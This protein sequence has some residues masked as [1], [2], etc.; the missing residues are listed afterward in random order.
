LLPHPIEAGQPRTVAFASDDLSDAS[1]SFYVFG[2][3]SLI[4]AKSMDLWLGPIVGLGLEKLATLDDFTI[5]EVSP[6]S[7][8]DVT[9]SDVT[10]LETSVSSLW[11]GIAADA[12]FALSRPLA[13]VV[14]AR[15]IYDNPKIVALGQRANL[16]RAEGA[17]G[18]R[19]VF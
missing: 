6:Y 13:L 1:M 3:F 18:L 15:L 10:T 17:V 19:L 4:H 16:L 7:S 2:L 14:T 8:E 11:Y 5:Q 12:E 9:I